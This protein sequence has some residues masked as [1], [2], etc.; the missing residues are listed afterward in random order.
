MVAFSIASV[1]SVGI[2]AEFNRMHLIS[3]SK[4]GIVFVGGV[5][6]C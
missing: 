1:A 2:E 5:A 4:F 3:E 6:F